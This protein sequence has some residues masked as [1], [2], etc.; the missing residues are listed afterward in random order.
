MAKSGMDIPMWI[1]FLKTPI[2]K[3]E[4]KI[5]PLISLY[6]FSFLFSYKSF[7][8][9]SGSNFSGVFK[10]TKVFTNCLPKSLLKAITKSW[11]P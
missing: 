9:S 4:P 8:L 5:N 10:E 3:T 2:E 1:G 11:F 6:F 7:N